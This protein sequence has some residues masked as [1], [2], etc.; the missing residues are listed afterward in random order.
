MKVGTL[1]DAERLEL[2]SKYVTNYVRGNAALG[3]AALPPLLRFSEPPVD[4]NY[5]PPIDCDMPK[6]LVEARRRRFKKASRF[7]ETVGQNA[8]ALC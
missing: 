1:L 6:E 7:D 4:Q 3:P 5:I 8:S 2:R